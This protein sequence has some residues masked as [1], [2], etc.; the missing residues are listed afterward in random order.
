MYNTTPRIV[1]CTALATT[2]HPLQVL[3]AIAKRAVRALPAGS[4]AAEVAEIARH[5][6]VTAAAAWWVVAIHPSRLL[7]AAGL[8]ADQSA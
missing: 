3:S 1:V 8:F 7:S 2:H 5:V 6:L 4:G